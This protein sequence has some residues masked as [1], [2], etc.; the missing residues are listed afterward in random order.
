VK[1]N[2]NLN[3]GENNIYVDWSNPKVLEINKNEKGGTY[4]YDLKLNK[5]INNTSDLFNPKTTYKLI[6]SESKNN[7]K[8]KILRFEPFKSE[9]YNGSLDSFSGLKSIYNKQGILQDMITYKKGQKNSL[10]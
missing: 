1:I 10:F 6:V 8:V 3:L 5:E 9:S 7:Y 4:Q 2:K